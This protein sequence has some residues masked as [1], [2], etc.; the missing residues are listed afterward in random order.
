[1]YVH[2]LPCNVSVTTESIIV[3]VGL[4]A[5]SFHQYLIQS[6]RRNYLPAVS[7]GGRHSV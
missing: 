6:L 5:L 3:T 7:C 1:M 2:T 4:I